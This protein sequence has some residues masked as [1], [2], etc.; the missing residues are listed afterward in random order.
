LTLVVRGST[1]PL[2]LMPAVRSEILSLDK[3]LP[4]YNVMTMNQVIT[5][6]VFLTRFSMYLLALFGVVA[7][8]MAAVGI[9]SVMSYS[10]TQ[11]QH[12]IGIRMAL[13]AVPRDVVKLIVRQGM[14]LALIG[15][16]VGLLAAFVVMR[17][18][19]SLLYGVSSTDLL[20]FGATALILVTVGFV[21][22]YFPA[23]RATKVDPM[24]ALRYE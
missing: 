18:L 20:T 17:L 8:V 14:S 6:S 24:I 5:N 23:R 13:G 22:S 1:D 3:E 19:S 7:L 16:G 2:R 15:V 9:Y 21:A 11:R 4:V 10:V 12:E